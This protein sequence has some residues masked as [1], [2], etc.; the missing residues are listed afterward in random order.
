MKGVSLDL[1]ME[2]LSRRA[3]VNGGDE[4]GDVEAEHD[5]G[6]QAEESVQVSRCWE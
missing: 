2:L 5:E 6:A 1:R 4:A 3:V